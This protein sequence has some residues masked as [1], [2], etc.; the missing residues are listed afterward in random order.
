MNIRAVNLNL[1]NVLDVL[2]T[3]QSVTK[4]AAKIHLS[5]PAISHAL[6]KLREIFQDQLLLKIARGMQPTTFALEIHEEVKTILAQIENLLNKNEAFDPA[7]SDRNFHLGVNTYSERVLI[8]P[9]MQF[10]SKIDSR[11]KI[12][13]RQ[14][15]DETF[16]T[17]LENNVIE[18]AIARMPV[19]TGKFSSEQLATENYVC[20]VSEDHPILSQPITLKN[21]L[22]YPHIDTA[23]SEKYPHIVN[24]T[25]KKI[26]KSRPIQ[27]VVDQ[28]LT[29][30]FVLPH[31]HLIAT[32]ITSFADYYTKNFPLKSFPCPLKIPAA[33][34]FQVW[35]H[36]HNKDAGHQWL[37]D[38]FREAAQNPL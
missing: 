4:A 17:Q 19:S 36:R 18:L 5:Q 25:L 7:T 28:F 10:L 29:L 34:I 24:E 33:E 26:N 20:L 31:T 2:L 14:V 15:V 11:I 21:Y 32:V 27:L 35:H 12:S 3:E 30:P 9:L 1:L 37:R 16:V 23:E 22:A 38:F 8:P 6:Q 13:L